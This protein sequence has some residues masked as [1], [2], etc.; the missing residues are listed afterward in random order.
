AA[1]GAAALANRQDVPADGTPSP[2]TA[3]EE[4]RVRD[5]MRDALR[6]RTRNM[7]SGRIDRAL[8][9][10]R[11]ELTD[12]QRERLSNALTAH[13]EAVRETWRAGREEGLAREEVQEEIALLNGKFT[14]TISEFI[15]AADAEAIST[16]L[17]TRTR[18]GA[19]GPG[20][21]GGRGG[22]R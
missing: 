9:N 18:G 19:G 13:Q 16:S 1:D 10:L 7:T 4:E 22:G 15:P 21:P 20:G 11:V 3:A 12:D 5:L 14:E 2:F 17:T 6:N 8:T